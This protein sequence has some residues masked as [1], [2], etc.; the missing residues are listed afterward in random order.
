M[1]LSQ[2]QIAEGI[3]LTEGALRD[4]S[5]EARKNK[6]NVLLVLVPAWNWMNN[7]DDPKEDEQ[8]RILLRRIA[9]QEDGVY[10]VDL[11]DI[12]S[13]VGADQFYGIER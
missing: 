5:A 10:L 3:N 13:R 6:A 2:E 1:V 12:V 4:L 9:D 11:T 7:L 8:Q